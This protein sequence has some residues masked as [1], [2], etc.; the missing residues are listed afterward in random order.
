MRFRVIRSPEFISWYLEQSEKTKDIIEGRFIRIENEGH[1]GF[2]NKFEGLI[3]LKWTSGLRIYTVLRG[4]ELI[5]ILIG[6]NKNGQE[7]DIKKA[8]KIAS[9]FF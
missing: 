3:E 7:K 8:K 1:F 6:G 5:I 2:I 9:R 4:N